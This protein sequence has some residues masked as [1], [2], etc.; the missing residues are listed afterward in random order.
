[1]S[2]DQNLSEVAILHCVQ[3]KVQQVLKDIHIDSVSSLF[4][5]FPL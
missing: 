5:L 3:S 4:S 2:A 1:M